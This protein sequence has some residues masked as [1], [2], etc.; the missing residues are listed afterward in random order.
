MIPLHALVWGVNAASHSTIC[1][2]SAFA[3]LSLA[4]IAIVNLSVTASH[5]VA[6]TAQPVAIFD[7]DGNV[8]T[9]VDICRIAI[10]YTHPGQYD[11]V[12]TYIALPLNASDWNSRFVMIGGGGWLAGDEAHTT[13]PPAF[14]YASSSTDG[15]HTPDQ[16]TSDWAFASEGNTNWPALMDFSS[17]ALVEAARLG[18]L[19]AQLYYGSVPTYSYW[20]GCSTG[21][22]QGQMMAQRYPE[23]FDGIISG[24][25]AISWH[26]WVPSGY[27]PVVVANTLGMSSSY[28]FLDVSIGML[29]KVS[30]PTYI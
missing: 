16:Q 19:A 3:A 18:K 6:V 13:L 30:F 20:T 21:G 4:N 25:P 9:T 23:E 7:P 12:N 29:R 22:R 2:T 1:E 10:Q 26:K 11:S 15:G 8:P 5:G 27:W 14:G 28:K 17:V 24:A